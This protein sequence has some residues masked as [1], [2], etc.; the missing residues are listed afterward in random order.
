MTRRTRSLLVGLGT[1]VLLAPAATAHAFWPGLGTGT[2]T[3]ATATMP[4]VAQPT[5]SVSGQ[6]VTIA[7]SQSSFLGSPLGAYTGGGYAVKRYAIASANPLSPN[8][9]CAA[10]V[11]GAAATLQCVE[12]NVPYGAWQ[13]DVTPLLSSFTG[14]TSIKSMTVSVLPAA[15]VLTSLTAANPTDEQ[16][17]GDLRLAWGAVSGAT[18]Y[19]VYRRIDA[20]SFDFDAPLNGATPLSATTTTYADSGSG[21]AA[22]TTYRYVVRAVAGSPAVESPRSSALG[23][24]AITRPAAP[25]SV[26]AT[27]A[28]AAR[29]DTSWAGVA[30]VTGYNIYRRTTTGSYDF[31]SP[32]NGA[33]LIATGSFVDVSAVNAV[34]YRYTVRSVITGAGGAQV[35]STSSPESSAVTADGVAPPAPV[36]VSIT[37][38]G[39]VWGTTSCGVTSG[40]RYIN[41]AGT[42]AVGVGA[43]IGTPEVGQTVVFS[44]TT[45]GATP[46]TATT[47]AAATAVPATLDLSGLLQGTMTL[48]ARTKDAAGNLSATISPTNVVIKDITG[49]A[50]TATYSGGLLGLDP[51]VSGTSECG[52]AIRLVKTAGGNVGAIWNTTTGTGTSYNVQ[53]EGP[54]LGLGSVSYD[55]TATDRAGNRGAT[56]STG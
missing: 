37:S 25:A 51:R 31:R 46:V 33:T 39:P 13:Y 14:T 17:T 27:A 12:T 32:L 49:P 18:G 48:T 8:A 23:A 56:V 41:A 52:A 5:G 44:A 38:G 28:A 2:G 34:T 11:S 21:L 3:A 45:A 40:T 19:N 50:V 30:G 9:G 15:P 54:L 6:T 7:W 35:E 29:N 1:A 36:A 42:G 53:V 47:A 55:V 16:T 43:T 10:T 4:G 26:T 24:V 20:G 22:G